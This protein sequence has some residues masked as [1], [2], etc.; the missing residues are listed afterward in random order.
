MINLTKKTL[1]RRTGLIHTYSGEGRWVG[2]DDFES[3]YNE[4]TGCLTIWYAWNWECFTGDKHDCSPG[5][6]DSG[7]WTK[8]D[9]D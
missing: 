5:S 1:Y 7:S 6:R 4:E 8:V 9:C 2:G 3:S